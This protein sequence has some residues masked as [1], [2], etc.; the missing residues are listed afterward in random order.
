[1]CWEDKLA[2]IERLLYKYS[3]FSTL[4]DAISDIFA[5]AYVLCSVKRIS[6]VITKQRIGKSLEFWPRNTVSWPLL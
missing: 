2:G 4:L 1:M 3:L 5:I 6:N